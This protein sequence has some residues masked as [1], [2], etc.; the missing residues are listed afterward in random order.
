MQN[1]EDHLDQLTYYILSPYKAL[2]SKILKITLI[3][4]VAYIFSAN[5]LFF[6]IMVPIYVLGIYLY[7]KLW[8]LCKRHAI[9]AFPFI[10]VIVLCNVP[11]LLLSFQIRFLVSELIAHL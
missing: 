8:I 5:A 10:S 7:C 2:F 1:S 11:F 4:F 3:L 9:K 6:C